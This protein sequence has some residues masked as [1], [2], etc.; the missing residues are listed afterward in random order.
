VARRGIMSVRIGSLG[1]HIF[2]SQKGVKRISLE[3][4]GPKIPNILKH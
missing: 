2:D 4:P 1:P 3:N